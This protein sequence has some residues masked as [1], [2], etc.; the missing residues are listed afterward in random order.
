MSEQQCAPKAQPS[1][2]DWNQILRPYANP[3]AARSL[4]QLLVTL[5]CLA[6]GFA[7]M[8][9]LDEFVGYWAALA[10]AVPT[11]LFMVRVFIIQHDCGHY[12]FFRQ[13]WACDWLGRVLGL[14]TLTPYMWWKRD[15]DWHHATSGDLSRRGYGDIDTLTVREYKALPGWRRFAYRLYRHPL[16][17]LGVGPFYQF[18]IRH[19]LPVGLRKADRLSAWSILGTNVALV[20]VL[21]GAEATFGLWKVSS[22]WLPVV[23]VAAT[24]GV[25]M[26]LIQHQFRETYWAQHEK[27]DFATAALRGCSYYKLPRPLEWLTGWIGYHHIHHLA[28]RIPNYHLRRCFVEVEAMRQVSVITIRESFK[29]ARLAL[30]DEDSQRL[31]TFREAA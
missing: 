2:V 1:I 10:L 16:V 15:H 4:T 20:G 25:W 19:R 27:W 8:V 5:G 30:W 23:L 22:F 18:V 24:A 14:L 31:L 9:V 12:S 28:S 17:L 29:C 26:F 3:T 7:G 13:R 11:G 21:I 6:A